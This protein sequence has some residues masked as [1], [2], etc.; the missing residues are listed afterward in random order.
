MGYVTPFNEIFYN[1]FIHFSKKIFFL[2]KNFFAKKIFVAEKNFF[3]K[4]L[5]SIENGNQEI[6]NDIN[7]E[8]VYLI[9]EDILDIIK[10]L[11]RN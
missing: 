1:S 4:N 8:M 7:K 2:K 5:S 11:K 3:R 10:S 9:K 6:N